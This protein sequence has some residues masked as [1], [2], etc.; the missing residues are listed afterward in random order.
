VGA[1]VCWCVRERLCEYVCAF[2]VIAVAVESMCVWVC[3]W[4]VHVWVCDCM[5]GGECV[6]VWGGGGG[7]KTYFLF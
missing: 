7:E 5:R 3:G 6:R 1:R 2:T 4:C